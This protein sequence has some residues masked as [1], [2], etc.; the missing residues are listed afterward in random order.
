M[1][2][3]MSVNLHYTGDQFQIPAKVISF[4]MGCILLVI[5]CNGRQDS[6]VLGE[7]ED[8]LSGDKGLLDASDEMCQWS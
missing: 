5:A 4:V 7:D 8:Y 1:K 3:K 2:N 6:Q